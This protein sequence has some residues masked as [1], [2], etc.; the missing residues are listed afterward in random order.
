ME[1]QRLLNA[2]SLISC[3]LEGLTEKEAISKFIRCVNELVPPGQEE[4]PPL[5]DE[6]IAVYNEVDEGVP[7][8]AFPVTEDVAE[9]PEPPEPKEPR[10]RGRK[11]KLKEPKS[12]KAPKVVKE[13]PP[14]VITPHNRRGMASSYSR[15]HSIVDA[16]K[17]GGTRSKIIEYADKLYVESGGGTNI[18]AL[19]QAYMETMRVL[20]ALKIVEQIG[21]IIQFKQ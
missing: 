13:K 9:P 17:K 15:I 6:V 14:K 12:P 10:K 16:V 1:A 11:P 21:E 20:K 8:W 2:A 18:D 3:S 4:N 19:T 5:P 7:D